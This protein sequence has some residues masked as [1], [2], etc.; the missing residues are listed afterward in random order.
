MKLGIILVSM[1]VLTTQL[2][3]QIDYQFK[4]DDKGRVY[5]EDVIDVE[6]QSKIELFLKGKD[7]VLIKKSIVQRGD[8]KKEGFW[9]SG[10]KSDSGDIL[11]EFEDK[12]EGR[13]YCK[14]R[15]NTL[16]YNNSGIKKNGGSFRY[17]L[18]LLFKDNKTKIVIDELYFEGGEMI[19]VNSGAYLNE[20][21]PEVFGSFG[22]SQIKKQWNLMRLQAINEFLSIIENYRETV[23][24]V[25]KKTSDW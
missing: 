8:D 4:L 7:W 3:G 9:M 21:Y 13:I 11:L 15:T 24:K 25:D 14:G 10:E 20:D 5:F 22:K 18:T 16:V 17:K 19:G 1:L 2:A 6:N 12:D 23:Q